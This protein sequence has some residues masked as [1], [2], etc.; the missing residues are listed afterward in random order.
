MT[1]VFDCDEA[2]ARLLEPEAAP[3]AELQAHLETCEECRKVARDVASLQALIADARADVDSHFPAPDVL[4]ALGGTPEQRRGLRL[5]QGT[6]EA[7]A[8]PASRNG[9]AGPVAAAG[10]R[11]APAR[12]IPLAIAI[13]AGL[14]AVTATAVL[15]REDGPRPAPR[16]RVVLRD[17]GD[18]DPTPERPAPPVDAPAIAVVPAPAPTP[19]APTPQHLGSER[20]SSAAGSNSGEAIGS[21]ERRPM[22]PSAP[23]PRTPSS[24][25]VPEPPAPAPGPAPEL[26]AQRTLRAQMPRLQ[27]CYERALRRDLRL[28]DATA[29]LTVDIAPEGGVESVTVSGDATAELRRCLEQTVRNAHFPPSET[30][31]RVSVPLRFEVVRER[32]GTNVRPRGTVME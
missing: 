28:G 16:E 27:N 25:Q 7:G 10:S 17:T 30:G 9:A 19:A 12:M 4:A 2:V 20:P 13:A 1:R 5:V 21:H 15:L 26:Q 32:M 11:S 18:R 24:S 29:D 14:V 22:A 6:A 3:S 8:R 31:L 23:A